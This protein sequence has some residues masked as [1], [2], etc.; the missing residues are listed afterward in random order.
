[1]I[2]IPSP[3]SISIF[4]TNLREQQEAD[5]DSLR[6]ERRMERPKKRFHWLYA[7]ESGI[8][9]NNNN[10]SKHLNNFN[11]SN[12]RH[13][14][15]VTSITSLVVVIVF[16]LFSQDHQAQ[17]AEAATAT[18][19]IYHQPQQQAQ[20]QMHTQQQDS[21]SHLFTCGKLYYRT[22]HLDQQRNVLYVGAM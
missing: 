10:K 18:N 6:L 13:D 1:M 9:N 2:S 20:V 7:D 17:L 14:H 19:S 4:N 11:N 15:L 22:F 12:T 16:L 21:S 5:Q 8:N 3:R